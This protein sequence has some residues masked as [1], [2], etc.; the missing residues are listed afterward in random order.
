MKVRRFDMGFWFDKE[1]AYKD[2]VIPFEPKYTEEERQQ[3]TFS[4][5]FQWEMYEDH[6]VLANLVDYLTTM[7]VSCRCK[8]SKKIT[9]TEEDL[10][11]LVEIALKKTQLKDSAF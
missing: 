5:K 1:E 11:F 7:L 2:N 4:K 10:E 3:I 6:R 9:L 8:K